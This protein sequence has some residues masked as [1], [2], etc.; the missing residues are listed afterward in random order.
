MKTLDY[1]PGVG[2]EGLTTAQITFTEHF[3]M[4]Y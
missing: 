1:L 3:L 4:F 2:V